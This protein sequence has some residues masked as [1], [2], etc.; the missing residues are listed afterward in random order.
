[1]TMGGY[2]SGR[3]EQDRFLPGQLARSKAGHDVNKLY[4]ILKVSGDMLYLADGCR[5]TVEAPKKKKKKH[6]WRM[7]YMDESLAGQLK[8]GKGLD[9]ACIVRAIK[10]FEEKGKVIGG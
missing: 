5:K 1:M 2:M 6:V 4:V 8:A 9:N 7:N 3:C 10:L